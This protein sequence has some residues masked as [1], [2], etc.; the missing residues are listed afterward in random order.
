MNKKQVLEELIS[1]AYVDQVSE[2]AALL[3]KYSL[4]EPLVNAWQIVNDSTNI[5]EVLDESLIGSFSTAFVSRINSQITEVSDREEKTRLEYI[6][7]DLSKEILTVFINKSKLSKETILNR[8]FDALEVSYKFNQWDF[9]RLKKITGFDLLH[10]IESKSE[11]P[12]IESKKS[13]D[14][15]HYYEWYGEP[16][17]LDDLSYNLKDQGFI[18]SRTQFKAL[19]K[20]VNQFRILQV[21]E[22]SI[23]LIVVLFDS[24]SEAKLVKAKGYKAK[25]FSPLKECFADYE[26]KELIKVSL[27]HINYKLKKN[28]R[29]HLKIKGIVNN[30]I[31]AYFTD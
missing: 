28:E 19:F 6:I 16:E 20:P 1:A 23:D 7:N 9:K 2:T 31:S 13:N 17:D 22:D 14:E 26:N 24:L 10:S 11:T 8:I 21:K 4:D 27:K 25:K 30:W 18:K 15:Q 5:D 3:S 12:V 29:K